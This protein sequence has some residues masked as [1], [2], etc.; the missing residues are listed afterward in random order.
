MVEKGKPNPALEHAGVLAMDDIEL[1]LLGGTT[2]G[3]PRENQAGSF[4]KF[5]MTLG[6]GVGKE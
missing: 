3:K 6:R 2:E 5:M 4:E 1:A